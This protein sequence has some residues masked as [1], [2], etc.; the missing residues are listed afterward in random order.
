MAQVFGPDTF[1]VGA[2]TNIDAYPAGDPDYAY[3]AGSGV[4][5]LVNAINDRVEEDLVASE[6]LARLIDA[7]APTAT[8]EV[9]GD[10]TNQAGNNEGCK[11]A[12][13]C[14]TTGNLNNCYKSF[15]GDVA[16]S[17]VIVERF[18]NGTGVTLASG[19]RGLSGGASK[20]HRLRT[21]RRPSC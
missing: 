21:T 9:I 18:D 6:P 19:D 3:N 7:A 15:F 14:A 10:V 2:D 13:R 12:A 4:A 17:E 11:L 1:T 8:Q 16:A 20:R 5:L